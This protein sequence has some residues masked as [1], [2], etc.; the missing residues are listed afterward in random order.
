MRSWMG[1]DAGFTKKLA[2]KGWIG[3]TW[4]K[5][6]GGQGRD[7]FSRYVLVEELLAAGAPVLAHWTA[8]RQSGPLILRYGSEHQKR[9]FLPVICRGESFFFILMSDPD[10]VSALLSLRTRAVKSSL[11]LVLHLHMLL[12]TTLHPFPIIYLSF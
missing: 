10:S 3:I 7:A 11:G 8:D 12:T 4:P 1:F 9:R 2:D 5:E 6:Y